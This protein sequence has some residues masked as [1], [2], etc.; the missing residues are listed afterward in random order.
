M[1][2]FPRDPWDMWQILYPGDP[3]GVTLGSKNMT[4]PE[5]LFDR[6]PKGMMVSWGIIPNRGP[7]I[8]A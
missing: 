7:K 8:S 2:C 4:S 6:K 5:N 1:Q 3:L